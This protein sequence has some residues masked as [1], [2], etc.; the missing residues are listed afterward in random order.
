MTFPPYLGLRL[1]LAIVIQLGEEV[2]E[3]LF[4]LFELLATLLIAH[5]E[6]LGR[7]LKREGIYE[8]LYK[9]GIHEILNKKVFLKLLLI[10]RKRLC[11]ILFKTRTSKIIP[12]PIPYCLARLL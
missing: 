5:E 10:L 3:A 4:V 1:F 11:K 12:L 2:F 6:L 8:I 7:G 9:R